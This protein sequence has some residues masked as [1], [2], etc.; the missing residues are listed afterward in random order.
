MRALV[1]TL[2]LLG[3]LVVQPVAAHH[4]WLQLVAPLAGGEAGLLVACFG[5]ELPYGDS[6][7]VL[8]DY[9][10]LV[11]ISPQGQRQDVTRLVP[12]G[13]PA[14]AP[15]TMPES[16]IWCAAGW[17][18]HVGSSTTRGYRRGHRRDLEDQGYTVLE[19]K[20]TF[21]YG[22]SYAAVGEPPHAGVLRVGHALEI[23]PAA[24]VTNL[25]AGDTLPLQ[26]LFEGEPQ[27][28]MVVSA[29]SAEFSEELAHSEEKDKFLVTGTTDHDGR[30]HLTLHD[31]GWWYVI[32]EQVKQNPEPGVD[33]LF[34][35]AVLT[36]HVAE[37]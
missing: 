35:S 5:H 11:L 30:V 17:R 20:H 26:V 14:V 21:R 16:G 2:A 34:R 7:P 18:E 23:V 29:T 6:P 19:C 27:R 33:N 25:K 24:T 3:L 4:N 9:D 31:A 8:E 15:V 37:R 28:D 12:L 13:V 1:N 10:E 32:T 22:K 36:F